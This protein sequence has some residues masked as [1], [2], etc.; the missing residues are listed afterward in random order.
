VV[1]LAVVEAAQALARDMLTTAGVADVGPHPLELRIKWP[2]DVYGRGLKVGGVLCG[3]THSDGFFRVTV[4]VGLNATNAE[5]T[6]CVAALIQAAAAAAGAPPGALLPLSREA[7]LAAVM[8]RYEALEARFVGEGGFEG[9][10]ESY[11]SHW[12]HT[13]QQV[14]LLE[15]PHAEVRLTIRGLARSGYL[16]AEDERGGLCELHPDGNS[17]DFW[18]GLIRRKVSV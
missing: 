7:L 8:G 18:K 2:N 15:P 12:L 17:L 4:G 11:L 13:G 10:R 14:T 5:P 6:T 16:L 1:T 3:S 9:L